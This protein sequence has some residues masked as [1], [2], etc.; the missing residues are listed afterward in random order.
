MLNKYMFGTKF[1]NLPEV[2]VL[3]KL[4]IGV[5]MYFNG[6]EIFKTTLTSLVSWYIGIIIKRHNDMK[7]RCKP[8]P[9]S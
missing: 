1:D 2:N 6:E 4:T 5:I 7:C 3:D 8:P 9:H